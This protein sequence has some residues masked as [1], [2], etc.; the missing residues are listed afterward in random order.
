[1]ADIPYQY[2]EALGETSV[3]GTTYSSK[4]QV[5]IPGSG[6]ANRR[7]MLLWS[8]VQRHGS[9]SNQ[10]RSRLQNTTAASTIQEHLERP[11]TANT[12]VMPFGGMASYLF[13]GSPA[14]QT[15]QFQFSSSGAASTTYL[16][17]AH[18]VALQMHAD[19]TFGAQASETTGILDTEEAPVTFQSLAITVAAAG[20]YC[21]RGGG[22]L[23]G[24]SGQAA[25]ALAVDGAEVQR[26]A[27]PAYR[28]NSGYPV[29]YLQRVVYLAAGEHTASIRIWTRGTA[30]SIKNTLIWAQKLANAPFFKASQIQIGATITNANPAVTAEAL[31]LSAKLPNQPVLWTRVIGV[32]ASADLLYTMQSRLNGA[33]D[34]PAMLQKSQAADFVRRMGPRFVLETPA[35]GRRKRALGFFPDTGATAWADNGSMLLTQ[36]AGTAVAQ[37]AGVATL[38]RGSLRGGSGIIRLG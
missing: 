25:V 11:Y 5:V 14:D 31:A 3:T 9:T 24:S 10:H 15:I 13:G 2:A 8:G 28:T 7:W 6:Q 36:L 18:L 34:G 21:I 16:Q 20:W 30:V 27:P 12:D 23:N 26:F 33:S 1:M 19:D 35:A 4:C 22:Q 17:D 37:A 38:G 29:F 32:G